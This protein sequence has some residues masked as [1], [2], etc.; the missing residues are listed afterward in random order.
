MRAFILVLT[1]I[2]LVHC[3]SYESGKLES[4]DGV[5]ICYHI[6]G[7]G[8]VTL[9]FVHGW[10]GTSAIWDDQVE[11][12]KNSFKVVTLD[13]PGFG[14]SGQNRYDWTIENYGNDILTLIDKFNL[15]NVI[16]VGH[17]MGG[18]AI[19]SAAR[20]NPVDI[21]GLVSVD[22]VN[23]IENYWTEKKIKDEIMLYKSKLQKGNL[24]GINDFH[25]NEDSAM[26]YND[27]LPNKM[28]DFWWEILSNLFE[29]MNEEMKPSLKQIEKPL[30]LINSDQTKTDSISIS[31]YS[32]DFSVNIIPG[33]AHYLFWDKPNEFNDIL[34][35]EIKTKILQ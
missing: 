25:V 29:W 9:I 4:R 16:L 6:E 14:Q 26:R 1:F 3:S 22:I 35:K 13:L 20:T 2:L 34:L 33:T 15:E 31:K 8:D 5:D 21:K 19:L 24:K 32:D 18:L 28:P 11:Y 30:I 10:S 7:K 12:F 23:D 27:V 17:S